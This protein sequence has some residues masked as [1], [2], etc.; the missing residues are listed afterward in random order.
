MSALLSSSK[1]AAAELVAGVLPTKTRWGR[2]H[3]PRFC[4]GPTGGA[5]LR[6]AHA[7][8]G[9]G[10]VSKMRGESDNMTGSNFAT[11]GSK[12]GSEWR[13]SP[14]P[15]SDES[16]LGLEAALEGLGLDPNTLRLM[17]PAA[18]AVGDLLGEGGMGPEAALMDALAGLKEAEGRAR[19]AAELLEELGEG[20]PVAGKVSVCAC[21]W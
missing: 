12:V 20:S 17:G 5:L 14:P 19:D 2:Q 3:E 10:G 18:A 1:T 8:Q 4:P 7:G 11:E 13:A 6:T 9:R 15:A 21:C 16:L